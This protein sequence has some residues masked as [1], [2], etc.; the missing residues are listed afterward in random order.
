[1]RRE[2]IDHVGVCSDGPRDLSAALV[3]DEEV[4]AVAPCRDVPP[5]RQ[6]LR[7][8]CFPR[9]EGPQRQGVQGG[10]FRVQ[11]SGLRVQG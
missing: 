5:L 3:P 8:L 11:G 7:F 4:P 6:E 1:M 2:P 10:G 9:G